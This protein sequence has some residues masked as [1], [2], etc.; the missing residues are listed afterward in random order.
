VS[1]GAGTTP[2][3]VTVERQQNP[4]DA[5]VIRGLL[6]SEGIPAI[7]ADEYQIWAN[8][9]MSQAL[10]GVKVQVPMSHRDQALDVLGAFRRGELEA[11][12]ESE[13]QLP[14]ITC[15]ACQSKDIVTTQSPLWG[16]LVMMIFLF[17]GVFFFPGERERCCNQCG[18][19][20]PPAN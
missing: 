17:L 11:A 1:D 5:Y 12:L 10:G 13:L 2:D 14:S 16:P 15:P 9:Q 18:A 4:W 7:V 8:W 3:L 6:E 19:R 20:V